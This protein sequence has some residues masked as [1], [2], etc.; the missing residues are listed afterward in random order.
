MIAVLMSTVQSLSAGRRWQGKGKF[1]A[2]Q[3][4]AHVINGR[5]ADKDSVVYIL[6]QIYTLLCHTLVSVLILRIG[7]ARGQYYWILDTGRLAWYHFNPI[8]YSIDVRVISINPQ[9]S[10]NF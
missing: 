6:L 4:S 5:K 9:M 10:V 7:T 2:I 8:F 1:Q 3:W